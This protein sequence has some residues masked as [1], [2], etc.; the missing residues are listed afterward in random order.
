MSEVLGGTERF[1][2]GRNDDDVLQEKRERGGDE[3]RFQC[4]NFPPSMHAEWNGREE[5]SSTKE[6]EEER[7][8]LLKEPQM[9]PT[10]RAIIL[11]RYNFIFFTQKNFPHF[12]CSFSRPL[13]SQ[14]INYKMV[15]DQ[16]NRGRKN[17]AASEYIAFCEGPSPFGRTRS[18]K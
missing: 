1:I 3:K 17:P 6:E 2:R 5:N 12:F 14:S 15:H 16:K 10:E 9:I 13:R 4:L 18:H 8:F 7:I 11:P